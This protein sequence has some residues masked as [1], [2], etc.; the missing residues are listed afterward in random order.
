PL[1]SSDKTTAATAATTVTTS[2]NPKSILKI[3][4]KR[5][6]ATSENA[7]KGFKN[8]PRNSPRVKNS[9]SVKNSPYIKKLNIIK[10][11]TIDPNEV[12]DLSSDE[13]VENN[14]QSTCN[15]TKLESPKTATKKN[16]VDNK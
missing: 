16:E 3:P 10:P 6:F 15:A 7:S 1:T 11:G 13:E 12:I 8:S 5:G 2:T 4:S 9:P 14:K